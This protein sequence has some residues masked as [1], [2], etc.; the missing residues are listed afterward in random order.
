MFRKLDLKGQE[1]MKLERKCCNVGSIHH[2]NKH[3]KSLSVL[4][5]FLDSLSAADAADTILE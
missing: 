1:D 5:M 4:E 2:T 3:P